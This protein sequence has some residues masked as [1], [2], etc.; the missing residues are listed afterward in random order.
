MICTKCHQ[1]KP[2]YQSD[3]LRCKECEKERKRAWYATPKGKILRALENK[4]YSEKP[5]KKELIRKNA[6]LYYEKHGKKRGE[7][8]RLNIDEWHNNNPKAI[9][10]HNEVHKA[11]MKGIITK[12]I[13]CMDCGKERKL[14]IS[15]IK[16]REN[17]C[18]LLIVSQRQS[19]VSY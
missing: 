1:E 12:A 14:L 15:D 6:Q 2:R 19:I 16:E 13:N 3:S 17:V 5:D 4:R 7:K 10:A 18:H 11:L 9:T 8:Y